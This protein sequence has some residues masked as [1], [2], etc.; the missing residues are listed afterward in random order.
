MTKTI[1]E[2]SG[3]VIRWGVIA[4]AILALSVWFNTRLSSVEIAQAEQRTKVDMILDIVKDIRADIK[5]P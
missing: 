2:N 3:V 5:K 1:T 4:G